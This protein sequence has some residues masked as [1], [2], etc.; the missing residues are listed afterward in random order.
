MLDSE[1]EC[2]KYK[3]EVEVYE[4]SA[5]TANESSYSLRYCGNPC[6]IDNRARKQ[7]LIVNIETLQK[8]GGDNNNFSVSVTISKKVVIGEQSAM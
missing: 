7:G 2:S 5:H 1:K 6:S 8:L 4:R 3:V